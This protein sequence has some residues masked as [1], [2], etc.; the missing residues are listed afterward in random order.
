MEKD[1]YVLVPREWLQTLAEDQ[2]KILFLLENR[3]DSAA[4]NSIG[5][6]VAEAEAKKM[7]GRKTTWFWKMRQSG[8]L[9]SSKVGNKVFYLKEDLLNLISGKKQK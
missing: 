9:P 8:R 6:Y 2:K 1:Y 5:D 3:G 4:V 7:L